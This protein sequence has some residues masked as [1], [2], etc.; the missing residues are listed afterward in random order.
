MT[1]ATS[2]DTLANLERFGIRPGLEAI[3]ALMAADDH[4]ESAYPGVLVAGT[5]GKG[6]TVAMA[7][8][9]L[10]AAGHRVG[11]YTSPHLVSLRERIVVDGSQISPAALEEEAGAFLARADA[12]VARGSLATPPT[13]FE[14]ITAIALSWFRR[15]E[16]DVAL[17][18]VGLGGRFDATN[19]V[20]ARWGVITAIGLD[21]QAYL[22]DTLE[23]IAAEKAG[24]IKSDMT[25]VTTEDRPAIRSV[26]SETA[27]A[28]GARWIDAHEGA[29]LIDVDA[30][31]VRIATPAH[32]YPAVRLGLA[33]AHQRVNALGAVRLLETIDR[34]G[35]PVAPSAIIAGLSEVEWA[36]R[37]QRVVFGKRTLW[38]DA[39]HN[40]SAA[41]ALAN[42]LQA[43]RAAPLP[44]VLAIMDDKDAAGIVRALAP[45]A[46]RFICT[47]PATPRAIAPERLAGLVTELAHPTPVLTAS[48]PVEALGQHHPATETLCVTGSIFLVGAVLGELDDGP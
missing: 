17:L 15:C 27:A 48:S 38:L 36:G 32:A 26:L 28:R 1:V 8:H 46:S 7:D 42:H 22:G 2:L 20:P 43:S 35:L 30:E 21:H 14:A 10:R 24:I 9:A 47:A 13:F 34:D 29:T 44:V 16:V 11:R 4:P 37:L 33:G 18:E 45:V 3:G 25:I 12:L 5:N 19:I 23:A 6:S 40:P 39:A 41:A 31:R